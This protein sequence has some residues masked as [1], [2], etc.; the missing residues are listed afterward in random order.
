MDYR[1]GNNKKIKSL[2]ETSLLTCPKCENKVNMSLFSNGELRLSADF[3][4]VSSGNVYFLVCPQCGAVY[5]VDE[6]KGNGFKKGEKLSIG[7]FDLNELKEFK[8][9]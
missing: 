2:G 6:E 9:D 8:V 3:P 1:L 4:I 5:G 7:N